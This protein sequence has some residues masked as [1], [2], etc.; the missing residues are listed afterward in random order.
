MVF[1]VF[2]NDAF[3]AF[4]FDRQF[5]EHGLVLWRCLKAVVH[6]TAQRTAVVVLSGVG[7]FRAEDAMAARGEMRI[8]RNGYKIS[9]VRRS[10]IE[11][12]L[13]HADRTGEIASVDLCLRCCSFEMHFGIIY[14]ARGRM[15]RGRL[16]TM[17]QIETIRRSS[18][19]AAEI[20]DLQRQ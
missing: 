14:G 18:T 8:F 6:L 17:A 13:T 16:S 7:I 9:R 10:T 3:G 20:L 12:R 19:L 5:I 11:L 2:G 1:V 4:A 15:C